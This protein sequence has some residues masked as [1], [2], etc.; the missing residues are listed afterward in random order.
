VRYLNC[1]CSPRLSPSGLW[2]LL[3]CLSVTL[4][5]YGQDSSPGRK[6]YA[7][8]SDSILLLYAR[9]PQGELIGQGSGFLIAGNRIV[10]NT[11]V[12]DAGDIFV[13]LG[14]ARVPAKLEKIDEFND[15]AILV[16]QVE[17]TAK[18]LI[19]SQ[20]VPAP[21][22]IAFVIGNPEGLEK[23]ISQGIVS[24]IRDTN[25]RKLLQ[26]SAPI[27][28]GSSGSPI[29]NSSGEVIGV[30]VSMLSSGQN[31]N[32][33]IPI[34]LVNVLLHASSSV[35][36][37]D[38]AATLDE[39]EKLGIVQ[40]SQ[41]FSAEDSSPYQETLAQI[42]ELL[43]QAYDEVGT[44]TSLLLRVAK[45]ASSYDTDLSVEASSRAET[46][47]PSSTSALL[48]AQSL[49][50][51]SIFAEQGAQK[52]LLGEAEKAALSAISRT[53][54]PSEQMYYTLG[55]IQE[56]EGSIAKADQ[57]FRL[58][59]SL[60]T[61]SA[62][63]SDYLDTLRALARTS[64]D[65]TK[66]AEWQHWFDLIVSTGKANPFDWSSQA[67][68]LASVE[69]YD[70]A[71]NAY[72]AAAQA[73]N[74]YKYWCFAADNYWLTPQQ[75]STLEAAR[76][77]IEHATG[78][79]DVDVYLG[80]AHREIADVLN[81]R[82]VYLEALNHAKE[83]TVLIPTNAW[84]YDDLAMALIGLGRFEEAVNAAGEAVQLSD[85]KYGFMHFHLGAAYFQLQNWQF[86]QQ[87]FQKAAELD[88]SN[89]A[90][91]YNVALCSQ[92]MGFFRDAIQ[93]YEE[94]LRRSPDAADKSDV[95]DQINKLKN[96]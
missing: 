67:Q 32:F 3:A 96:L 75:D 50:D 14:P 28:H 41:E 21:G 37:H 35:P 7:D 23:T 88:K 83:A 10:T 9:S 68:R 58:A 79:K 39:V 44:D 4:Q 33:G 47:Q 46:L 82:G 15:T 26:I 80:D 30:A 60:E 57:N 62:D 20:K 13:Q 49:R 77:C 45:V 22:E 89:A 91:A 76:A 43:H 74:F 59:L 18:P 52:Q 93:W 42:K 94:Y 81:D 71:A 87:S 64:Y 11:H 29:F 12:A 86:A 54:T 55:D 48:Y 36:G 24:G 56:D 31:L 38:A 72:R 25:G 27:S 65:L 70:D 63:S 8:N 95:L 85:G 66:P 2:L 73:N 5:A 61:K 6:I 78:E 90:A 16:I 92:R 51:K 69:K 19:L 53:R 1:S 40:Q 34:S 17:I 84:A